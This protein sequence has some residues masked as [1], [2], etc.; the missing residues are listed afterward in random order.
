MLNLYTGGL[1][2]VEIAM[3]TVLH[4]IGATKDAIDMAL[5]KAV[6]LQKKKEECE[7]CEQ[8]YAKA[9]REMSLKEREVSLRKADAETKKTVAEAKA[10][11]Q[12]TSETS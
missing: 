9:D 1:V 6:E 5:E 7:K 11:P 10:A 4:A 2:P 8:D 3:P 12:K